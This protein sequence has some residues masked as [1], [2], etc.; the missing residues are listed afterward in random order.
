MTDLQLF[1]ALWPFFVLGL[2]IL[3][4]RILL[5]RDLAAYEHA[6]NAARQMRGKEAAE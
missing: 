4:G 6:Q 3:F 2:F 1:A 5:Q